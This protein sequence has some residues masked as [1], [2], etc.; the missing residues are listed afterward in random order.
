MFAKPGFAWFFSLALLLLKTGCDPT[1]TNE[2]AEQFN[3]WSENNRPDFS[4]EIRITAIRVREDEG[5]FLSPNLE[6]EVHMYE[7]GTD[8]HLGCSGALQ[9]LLQVVDSDVLYEVDAWFTKPDFSFLSFQDIEDKSIYLLVSEND[10]V[11]CPSAFDGSSDDVIGES[12]PFAGSVLAAT[13]SLAFGQVQV[14]E[15][16]L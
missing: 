3:V 6:I 5:T 11:H 10:D 15:I 2:D 13:Q 12:E 9:G 4:S 14:L 16:G 1:I 7:A 8:E